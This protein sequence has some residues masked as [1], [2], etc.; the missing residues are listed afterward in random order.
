GVVMFL[1]IIGLEMR[2]ARL[3]SLRRQIFGLG[4]LQVSVCSALLTVAGIAGGFPIAVSFVAGAGFVM[5][6][7]AIV[8]QTLEERG[9][10]TA[11]SGQKMVS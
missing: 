8:M 6:S 9:E 10:I 5:T 11:P 7:T 1:F 3:W 2:P 4:V